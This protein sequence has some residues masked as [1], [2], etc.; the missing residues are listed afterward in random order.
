[1]TSK[2]SDNVPTRVGNVPE[3]LLA[4]VGQQGFKDT[5]LE[6]MK[7]H[8][9]LNRISLIQ[10][11]S[12]KEMKQKF[13]EG[14]LVIP[15]SDVLIAKKG[16]SID[17]VPLLF[18]DQFISW[19]DRRDKSGPKI[20]A[21]SFDRGSDIAIK[22]ADPVKRR[23]EYGPS[24]MGQDG[25]PYRFVMSHTHHLDF[26]VMIYSGAFKG[27]MCALSFSR[28]DWRNGMKFI[29]QI[30]MRKI[31]AYQA[32]LWATVWSLSSGDRKNEKGEWH[33]L[34][35]DSANEPWV[36][37]AD[38]AAFQKIHEE[39]YKDYADRAIEVGHEAADTGSDEDLS[40]SKEM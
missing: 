21:K 25:K 14:S 26:L 7:H 31:G 1:M 33:G 8:R 15:A 24:Q 23:E 20:K 13:G 38:M 39:L 4:L 22:A 17:F 40:A 27:T 11:M 5:S 28:S 6:T 32:P 29:S 18:F 35:V 36:A 2:S 9:V 34:D 37:E 16:E 3:S 30:K 19:G 10:G 12:A